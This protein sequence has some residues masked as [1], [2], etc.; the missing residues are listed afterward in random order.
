[1]S[2]TVATVAPEVLREIPK[3]E[4]HCHLEGSLR[5]STLIEL[6][7]RREVTLPS[8]DPDEL[9]RYGDLIEFLAVYELACAA[10]VTHDDFARVTYEAL[11][12]AH[13]ANVV[14]R[15]MFFNPTLHPGVDY[16]H[17]LAGILEGFRSAEIDF[18]ITARLIPS[19]YRQMPVAAAMEMLELVVEHR[20]DEV[21]GIGMDGD[22]LRDPPERFAEVYAAA[23]AAGLRRTCH[24]AHDGPA[25]FIVTCL[26]QLGCERVDHGYHVVDDPR[27]MARLVD[28][29]TAFLCAP[30]TL[31]LCGWPAELDASPVR[32]MI[33]AGLTVVLNS[34]DPA[35]FHTDLGEEFVK[36]CHGWSLPAER[37]RRLVTDAIDAAWL[38]DT[39]RAS[40]AGR[41]VPEL[42]SLLDHHPADE[43][44]ETP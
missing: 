36:A 24:V 5:P 4:L 16:E 2:P 40:L 23:G 26:E 32:T 30:P 8:T 38:D 9:Y 3:V 25:A 42:D 13:R 41:V 39:E 21:V 1:M 34:D 18:G 31:P 37:V 10:V 11:A 27:L 6:A 43:V 28:A 7:A 22:E 15:E 19:I 14:H 35:M 20:T 29:G 17:M 33:D 44:A 12:D